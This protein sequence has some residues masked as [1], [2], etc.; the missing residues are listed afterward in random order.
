VRQCEHPTGLLQKVTMPDG[1]YLSYSYDAAHRLTE[2]DDALGDRLVYTLDAAGNRQK[3]DRHDPSGALMRT[4]TQLYNALGQLWQDLTSAGTDAQATLY[5]YDSAGNQTTINAPL[6]RTTSNIYDE[7][8]RLKQVTDS[9]GGN[10]VFAY[11]AI[12]NL[13]TVTDPR[14]L[15]TRY[16][17]NG[18]GDLTQLQ[19]PDTGTSRFTRDS[20]GTFTRQPMREARQP[21]T[22][23]MA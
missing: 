23:T 5:G 22:H 12:D 2:V 11:D 17:Y 21:R 15:V 16:T 14:G 4:H 8:N 18:L 13:T 6:A 7:L 10:A 9:A 1:S 3:D 20:A 19:S